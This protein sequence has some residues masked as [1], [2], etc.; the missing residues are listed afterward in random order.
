MQPY[1]FVWSACAVGVFCV[2][3]CVF[4]CGRLA[5]SSTPPKVQCR[6]QT[7]FCRGAYARVF[8]CGA[9]FTAVEEVVAAALGFQRRRL[10]TGVCACAT[11]Q[12]DWER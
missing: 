9:M 6:S 5:D 3:L 8:G 2:C 11:W 12:P 10:H 4:V 1:F 7:Y